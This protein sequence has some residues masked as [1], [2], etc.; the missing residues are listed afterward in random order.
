MLCNINLN[1]VKKYGIFDWD[2]KKGKGFIVKHLYIDDRR[3][4]APFG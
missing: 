2:R 4:E 1:I 3:V